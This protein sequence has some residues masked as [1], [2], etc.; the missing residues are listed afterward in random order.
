MERPERSLE[1]PSLSYETSLL[2][3]SSSSNRSTSFDE[4]SSNSPRSDEGTPRLQP[5]SA[6]SA[7]SISPIAAFLDSRRRLVQPQS[8][9]QYIPQQYSNAWESGPRLQGPRVVPLHPQHA[10][11]YAEQRRPP[12]DNQFHDKGWDMPYQQVSVQRSGSS[13]THPVVQR[14][15]VE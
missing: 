8:P 2:G 1:S 6:S 12:Y 7:I 5:S 4:R 9:N 10:Y 13:V 14:P 11:P 3:I 15:V